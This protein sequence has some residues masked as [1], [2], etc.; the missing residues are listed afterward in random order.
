M[1][2]KDSL[3]GRW[4]LLYGNTR[5]QW[6]VLEYI[7]LFFDS[8]QISLRKTV[9]QGVYRISCLVQVLLLDLPSELVYNSLTVM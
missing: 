7:I 9:K 4:G 1:F 2:D 8:T 5:L 6:G 3:F